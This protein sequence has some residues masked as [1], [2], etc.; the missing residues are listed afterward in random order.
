MG[1]ISP[2]TGL[3]VGGIT[4]PLLVLLYFLKLR[5]RRVA[6]SST[7]LWHKAIQDLQVNSP[8]QKLRRNLLLL[9]QLLVLLGMLVALAR[10]TVRGVADPGDRVVI[11]IDHSA[12]MNATDVSPTRLDRAKDLA[13]DLVDG[14][15]LDSADSRE[16]SGVMVISFTQ[17]ARVVQP[18]TT[19][20]TVLHRAVASIEP[21]DQASRLD[22]ALKLV[23]PF[24]MQQAAGAPS[25]SESTLTVYVLSDG[26]VEQARSVTVPTAD[27]RFVRVGEQNSNVA[28]VSFSARRDFDKPHRVSVLARLANFGPDPVTTT[29]TLTVNGRAQR[30]VPVSLPGRAGGKSGGESGGKPGER[31][32]Q[33]DLSLPGEAVLAVAHD[34]QDQLPADDGASLVIQAPR[35]LRV[36]LV[37]QGNAFLA[38]AI[39][40]AGVRKLVQMTPKRYEDQN[41]RHLRRGAEGTPQSGF[42]VIIFDRCRPRAVPVVDSIYFGA[43]PPIDGLSLIGYS[44]HEPGT[45]SVLDWDR[46]HPLLRYVALDDLLLYKPGRLA[47]PD[48]AQRLATGQT[49]PVMALVTLEGVNHLVVS[50]EIFNSNWPM[51]ISFPVMMSNALRWLGLAGQGQAAISFQPGEV[52]QVRPPAGLDALEY[53]GP[54]PLGVD[55]TRHQSAS[56]WAVV[57][58][59]VRAGV[60]EAEGQIGS[61]WDRLAVNILDEDES[62]IRPVEQLQI[63]THSA[64][65]STQSVQIR[66]E[67]WPW[68]VMA[69]LGVLMVEWVIYTRRMHI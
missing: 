26:R 43:A 52:A 16:S 55:L 34:H 18:F 30:V 67:V 19:D 32:F 66:R 33:Y 11:L 28:V 21:T 54:S 63:G 56:G 6:V 58:P 2:L 68:F 64:A 12:S 50:F 69:A 41:P 14:V 29:S 35:R 62:D 8:F 47:L 51:Q 27:F 7:L 40:S 45:Q 1:F 37:T 39:E 36:L 60:Y 53:T 42:D 44:E 48:S 46:Q 38:H 49:G 22:E 9:L 10:P 61:P 20:P 17:R 24:S 3:I 65:A 23:E 25:G 59:F 31:S 13:V 4:V 15:A 5:R 57:G